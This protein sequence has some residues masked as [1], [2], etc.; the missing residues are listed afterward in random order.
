[1]AVLM[2]ALQLLQSRFKLQGRSRF[3]R[4]VLLRQEILLKQDDLLREVRPGGFVLSVQLL[5]HVV[6]SQTLLVVEVALLLALLHLMEPAV[7]CSVFGKLTAETTQLSLEALDAQ[8]VTLEEALG[9]G[10][11]AELFCQHKLLH[12]L[13]VGDNLRLMLLEAML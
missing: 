11:V 10:L 7:A 13:L 8:L 4:E 1:M 6:K 12:H 9:L 2:L 5:A 3:G